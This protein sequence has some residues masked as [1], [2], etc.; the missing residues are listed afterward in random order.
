M[1]DRNGLVTTW[2]VVAAILTGRTSSEAEGRR[3]A[4]FCLN[5]DFQSALEAG[6]SGTAKVTLELGCADGG[7]ETVQAE[8]IPRPGQGTAVDGFEIR[9]HQAGEHDVGGVAF[10]Q[11]NN[12]EEPLPL[13]A[14]ASPAFLIDAT[15]DL[16]ILDAND[17]ASS[18]LGRP[19]GELT[20]LKLSE[21][22]ELDRSR[23]VVAE[24]QTPATPAPMFARLVGDAGT[25]RS[26]GVSMVPVL[27]ESRRLSLCVLYD[28]SGW[29]G[30]R[31]DLT[32][33][34]VEL[35]RLARHDHLTGLF[36]RPMF[37][38]TLAIANARL[39]RLGGLLG[40]LYIDLDGF[41]PV[42]DRLGHDAGDRVLVE[43]ANRLKLAVRSSDVV[44]R[45]GGDE[46]GAILENLKRREDC[47]KVARNIIDRLSDPLH[48]DGE[49]FDLSASIGAV[50]VSE[51]VS[52]SGALVTRAD[53]MM[54]KAKAL[55]RGR[56][57]L[58]PSD[59]G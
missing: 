46:F 58:A 50:V 15:D 42:N 45:L 59:P 27:W 6:T 48:V 14:Q 4:S 34:N 47:L 44:A 7:A 40:V 13:D 35:S 56:A 55:G 29:V 10:A 32:K 30:L 18:V 21:L 26:Y 23:T 8:I 37:L 22:V 3:F 9:L 43:V 54:Y 24:L 5:G 53:R 41:K 31:A 49:R 2:P 25:I 52:D 19:A 17:A 39:N 12:N 11:T 28:V 16:R 36:N 1:V 38:D 20:G 51:G 33:M 57:A